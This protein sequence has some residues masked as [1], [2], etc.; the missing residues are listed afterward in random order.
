MNIFVNNLDFVLANNRVNALKYILQ[1]FLLK[2]FE[3]FSFT[4][5]QA[6]VGRAGLNLKTYPNEQVIKESKRTLQLSS[7]L[8]YLS[9]G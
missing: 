4:A 1:D 5:P 2:A 7:Y 3:F 9:F 6:P 8:L